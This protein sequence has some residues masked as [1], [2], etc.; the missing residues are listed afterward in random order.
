MT[1]LNQKYTLCVFVVFFTTAI[2]K[3]L[4]VGR[5]KKLPID[6]ERVHSLRPCTTHLFVFL[7]ALYISKV[8]KFLKAFCRKML[9]SF[10]KFLQRVSSR[11]THHTHV[12]TQPPS[13]RRVKLREHG[14]LLWCPQ[15]PLLHGA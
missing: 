9:Q 2:T 5:K 7:S 1:G 10:N 12:I 14:A 13:V 6:L 15:V 8:R 4:C 3:S 11:V